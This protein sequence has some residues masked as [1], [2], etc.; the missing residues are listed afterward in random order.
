VTSLNSSVDGQGVEGRWKELGKEEILYYD[1][2]TPCHHSI[3]FAPL[4]LKNIDILSWILYDFIRGL[5]NFWKFGRADVGKQV[6]EGKRD[7]CIS[8]DQRGPYL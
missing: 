1:C 6:D 3:L 4:L 8:T 5:M 2:M 7:C